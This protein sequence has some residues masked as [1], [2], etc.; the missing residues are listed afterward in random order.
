LEEAL[1]VLSA[2]GARYEA[3]RARLDLAVVAHS[4]GRS[5]AAAS[6]LDTARRA[7]EALRLRA[8]AERAKRVGA[9]LA[10]L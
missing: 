4:R 6:H 5:D 1:D 7:F 3:A 8:W 2:I 9:E 10:G